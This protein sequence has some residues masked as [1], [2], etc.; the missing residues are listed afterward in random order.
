MELTPELFIA[1]LI[2]FLV[3][4]VPSAA[5]GAA[6]AR[7]AH[8]PAWHGML[9]GFFLPW[10]GLLFFA[11]NQ[12][13]GRRYQT[14]P[15][16]YAMVMLFVAAAMTMISTFL[17]WAELTGDVF[18]GGELFVAPSEV[19]PWAIVVWLLALGLLVGALGFLVRWGFAGYLACAIVVAGI[20][21]FLLSVFVFD[22]PTRL[23]A[24]ARLADVDVDEVTFAMGDGAWVA[25]VALVA[26]Y[27]AVIV[28]PFGLKIRRVE[29][30]APIAPVAPQQPA[31]WAV[32]Q[33]RPVGPVGP[34]GPGATW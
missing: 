32:Q 14:G 13:P 12:P 7:R 33:Q 1:L 26:A 18:D 11:G 16:Q 2:F 19:P 30:V 21:G 20:G 28:A 17:T 25:L 22:G 10:I 3:A 8:R 23:L 27:V 31:A 4:A 15:A 6:L 5:S 34:G 9:A 29:P 24:L